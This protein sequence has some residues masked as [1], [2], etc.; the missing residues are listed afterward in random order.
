[1]KTL[2]FQLVNCQSEIRQFDTCHKKD[3]KKRSNLAEI[4]YFCRIASI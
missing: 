3:T 2:E 4:W 1:L